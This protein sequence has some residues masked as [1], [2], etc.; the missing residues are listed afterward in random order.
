MKKRIIQ[1]LSVGFSFLSIAVF[2]AMPAAAYN[3]TNAVNYARAHAKKY[4]T[5]AYKTIDQDCTNFISQCVNAGGVSMSVHTNHGLKA[6]NTKNYVMDS[7]QNYWYHIKEQQPGLLGIKR[8]V[9]VY[10]STW[11]FVDQ[12]RNYMVSKGRATANVKPKVV[13][14]INRGG[15]RPGDLLQVQGAHSVI[16][17]GSSLT[18]CSHSQDRLDEPISTFLKFAQ[19]K[20]GNMYHIRNN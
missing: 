11:S 17:T 4:N 14:S 13:D 7:N 2:F 5:D 12:F 8:T 15:S 10:S 20:S 9:Y 6:P 16:I 18:Y 19:S 1:I 3:N